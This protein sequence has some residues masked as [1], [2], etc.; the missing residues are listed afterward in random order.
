MVDAAENGKITFPVTAGSAGPWNTIPFYTNATN[1][2]AVYDAAGQ[3]MMKDST[4]ISFDLGTSLGLIALVGGGIILAC[5]V[6]ARFLSWGQSEESVSAVWKGTLLLSVW[7]V[8]SVLSL[9]MITGIPLLG[10]FFY[11]FL[12][13]LYCMGVINQVGHP[14]ED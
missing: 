8:F 14:G 10:P 11:M 1:T 6:G 4:E 3:R 5:I 9:S 13:V 2:Y 12:T 7:G